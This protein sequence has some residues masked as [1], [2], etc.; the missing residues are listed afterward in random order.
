MLLLE[1]FCSRVESNYLKFKKDV[2]VFDREYLSNMY[3]R[4]E[5]HP[6]LIEGEKVNGEIIGVSE[7][8]KLKVKIGKELKE[9]GMKEIIFFNIKFNYKA[10]L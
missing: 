6:F 1:K 5:M 9:Y 3:R 7:I 10:T 2:T 8:G 4:G